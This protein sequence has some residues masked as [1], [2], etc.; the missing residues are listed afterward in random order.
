[1]VIDIGLEC[2]ITLEHGPGV[3]QVLDF[4]FFQ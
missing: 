2:R 3:S 1:M 4:V